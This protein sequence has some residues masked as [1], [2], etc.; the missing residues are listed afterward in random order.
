MSKWEHL[1][2]WIDNLRDSCA[3][4]K[5][6]FTLESAIPKTISV[7]ENLYIFVM[8]TICAMLTFLYSH[9]SVVVAYKII[10]K[11]YIYLICRWMS[12]PHPHHLLDWILH[13]GFGWHGHGQ[14]GQVK[15]SVKGV[16]RVGSKHLLSKITTPLK[17]PNKT[18][19]QNNKCPKRRM[20]IVSSRDSLLIPTFS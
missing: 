1:V 15:P 9:K 13:L 16:F 11:I 3:F 10:Y 19:A 18:N 14:E 7:L 12:N 20:P 17:L 5:C 2:E 4:L 6:V 8:A